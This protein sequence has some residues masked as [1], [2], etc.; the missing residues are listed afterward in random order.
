LDR[1]YM[2]ILPGIGGNEM[3]STLYIFGMGWPE[4]KEQV[5]RLFEQI[6]R[7]DLKKHYYIIAPASENRVIPSAEYRLTFLGDDITLEQ[8][9]DAL[10]GLDIQYRIDRH[11][12][13]E[14]L[15]QAELLS[16]IVTGTVGN[17]K[18]NPYDETEMCRYCKRPRIQIDDIVI[19]KKLMGRKDI[20]ATYELEIVITERLAKLFE[21]AKFTGYTLR[22]VHHYSRRLKEEP[23]L[24]QLVPTH[25]LPAVASPPTRV[26]ACP[27]CG[28]PILNPFTEIFYHQEDLQRTG[29]HDFNLAWEGW[30]VIITQ[31]VY[32]LLV[33]HRIRKFKVEIIR[34]L[35]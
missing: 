12:T 21:R 10:E 3:K 2:A 32:R 27:L 5:D 23:T 26:R 31:P 14:E 16:L 11:Y 35:D 13:R 24:Y 22:P 17:R 4:K 1:G 30:P 15:H 18:N 28:R 9:V 33:E 8:I 7:E 25:T 29:I 20:A 34:I 19:D 6:G